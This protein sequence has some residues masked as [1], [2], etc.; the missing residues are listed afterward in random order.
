MQER[1]IAHRPRHFWHRDEGCKPRRAPRAISSARHTMR[2]P[3]QHP[4]T[5]STRL[6]LVL[7]DR[8]VTRLAVTTPDLPAV[9]LVTHAAL[10]ERM[11][12]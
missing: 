2:S 6:R 12:A 10:A 8:R 5:H 9:R 11:V 4:R 1:R 7:I 3:R